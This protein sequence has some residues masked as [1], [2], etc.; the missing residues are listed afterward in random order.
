MQEQKHF[1]DPALGAWGTCWIWDGFHAQVGSIPLTRSSINGSMLECL[2][3]ATQLK[4]AS[5]QTS[6]L[7][8]FPSFHIDL[9]KGTKRHTSLE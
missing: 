1:R 9:T 7:D 6:L 2:L 8:E 3:H 5:I 4:A